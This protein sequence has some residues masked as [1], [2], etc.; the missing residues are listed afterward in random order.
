MSMTTVA[1]MIE[2]L[3]TF[4]QDAEVECTLSGTTEGLLATESTGPVDIES[5][6]VVDFTDEWSRREFPN[7]AGK[8]ILFIRGE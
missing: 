7:Q 6:V 2:W 4:P 1:Q 3:N 5:C 8:T